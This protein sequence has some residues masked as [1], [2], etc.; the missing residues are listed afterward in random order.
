MTPPAA[1]SAPGDSSVRRDRRRTPV[2]GGAFIDESTPR[3]TF[4]ARDGARGWADL[5]RLVSAAHTADG[6]PR[7]AWE[8]NHAGGLTVLLGPDSDVGRA[9][10]AGRPDRAARLLAPWR[11]VYG[12]ALRLEAVWHGRTGTGPGSLRLAARTLGFAAEQRVRP[13][14]S[15]AVRYADP[16]LGPV[17]DVLDAAR[18]LV[19][20]DPA[21]GW[22]P[23]RPG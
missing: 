19:P 22:T 20:V 9:L 16:G 12:D 18:R 2:R 6:L 5:C 8:D 15:N 4:L 10:A 14:L 17:A 1:A 21:K 7:L 13:V 3:V 11:E 23:A